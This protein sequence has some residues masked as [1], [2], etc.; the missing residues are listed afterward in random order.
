[1]NQVKNLMTGQIIIDGR[2]IFDPQLMKQQGFT[3]CSVGR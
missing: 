2:N 3:Y 1:L